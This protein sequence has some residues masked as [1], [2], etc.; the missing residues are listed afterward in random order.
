M[1]RRWRYTSIFKRSFGRNG[2]ISPTNLEGRYSWAIVAYEARQY[3]LFIKDKGTE[4]SST[5]ATI[6][7]IQQGHLQY[8]T[9]KKVK[10]FRDEKRI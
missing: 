2:G 7:T 6:G 9:S 10:L 8:V 1:K 5:L 3:L 4:A